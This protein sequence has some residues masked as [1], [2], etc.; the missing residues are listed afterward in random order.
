VALTSKFDARR[1]GLE[2]DPVKFFYDCVE[3]AQRYC[4]SMILSESRYPPRIKSGACFFGI[5][6]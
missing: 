6:L 1:I 4:W 3:R 2:H 5:M